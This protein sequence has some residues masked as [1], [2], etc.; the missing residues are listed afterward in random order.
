MREQQTAFRALDIRSYVTVSA[1]EL[2]AAIGFGDQLLRHITLP[3]IHTVQW[4]HG[5][6]AS[7]SLWK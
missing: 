1:E 5:T 4:A 7:S 3:A 2:V 6:F